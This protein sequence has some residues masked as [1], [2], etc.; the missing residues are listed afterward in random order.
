[1]S[2]KKKLK[3][4]KKVLEKEKIQDLLKELEELLHLMKK[5]LK[6]EEMLNQKIKILTRM[7]MEK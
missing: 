5:S 1:M 7:L 6:K 2:L 3:I 4:L